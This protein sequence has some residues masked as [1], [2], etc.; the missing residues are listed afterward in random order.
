MQIEML[1]LGPACLIRGTRHGDSRG[2]FEEAWSQPKLANA[3]FNARFVQD[4]LAYTAQP[5][6]LRGLHCQ[7]PSCAQGKLLRVITGAIRDVIVDAREGSTTYGEHVK[8]DLRADEPV[9]IWVPE[10]FLHGLVTLEPDTRVLYKV[11]AA[12][13]AEHDMAVAWNDPA[14]DIDWGVETPTLSDKDRTAPRLADVSPLFPEGSV[15]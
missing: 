2:W 10:G 1:G 8:I 15:S 7:R 3:D 13:S 4:N 5:G 14:L 11:T 12:F 9:A 6:T